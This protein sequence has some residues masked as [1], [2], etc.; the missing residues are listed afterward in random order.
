MACHQYLDHLGAKSMGLAVAWHAG[1]PGLGGREDSKT[2]RC[3]ELALLSVIFCDYE[4]NT[5][6]IMVIMVIFQ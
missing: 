1:F 5:I 3:G 2:L 4:S 6:G